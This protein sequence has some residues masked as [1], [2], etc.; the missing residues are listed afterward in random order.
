MSGLHTTKRFLALISTLALTSGLVLVTPPAHAALAAPARLAPT[1]PVSNSMPTLS[2]GRVAGATSYTVQVDD[3]PAFDTPE[4]SVTTVNSRWVPT[5]PLKDGSVHWRV[6]AIN[7]AGAGTWTSADIQV[8]ATAA[9]TPISPIDSVSL[10]QPN[11]PPLLTWSP[12]AGATGYT[13]QVANDPDFVTA[14][15]SYAVPGTSLVLPNPQ[16][17]RQEGYFW[18]VQAKRDSGGA[19]TTA[20]SDPAHYLVGALPDVQPH[21]DMSS[22][23]P[24]QDVVLKWLPVPGATKYEIKVG[25]DPDI[26]N[27][28]VQPPLLV[29]GTSYSPPTTYK[30]DQ[31]YWQVRA[32]NTQGDRSEWPAVPWVFQRNWPERPE[33]IHPANTINPAVGDDFYYQWS[34]VNTGDGSV[35]RH[36]SEYQLDV[37]RDPNF[38]P[39]SFE[40]CAVAATTFTAGYVGEKCMPAQGIVTYW[41]VRAID[42]PA[43]VEGIYSEIHSFIYNSGQVQQLSPANGATVDVPTLVWSPARD[44][45]RYYVEIRNAADV[46]VLSAMTYGTSWTA[47]KVLDPAA[48]PFTWTVQAEDGNES[49]SPKYPGRSFSLSGVQPDSGAP[50]LTPLTGGSGSSTRFPSL[51]W[52][53]MAN[54]KSYRIDIG[55]HGSGFVD[56]D[57]TSHINKTAYPYSA[58]TDTDAHYLNQGSYDW[59]VHAYDAAGLLIGTGPVGTF[60][61]DNLAPVAG[62]KIALTGRALDGAPGASCAAALG[63]VVSEEDICLGVPATPVLD[64]DSVPGAAGYLVYLANDRALTN[65][66]FSGAATVNSRWTPTSKMAKSALADNTALDAYYWYI[67]PCKLIDPLVCNPDPISTNQVATHAFR[68]VAPAVELLPEVV[69]PPTSTGINDVTFTWRDY[70]DTNLETTFPDTADGVPAEVEATTYRIDVSQSSTFTSHVLGFPATVDQT[71]YTPFNRTLPEGTL[72]WRVQAIDVEGNALAWSTTRSFSKSSPRVSLV[73]PVNG[74]TASGATPFRWHSAPGASSYQLEVYTLASPPFQVGHRIFGVT[75]I[76]QTAYQY[77]KYLP[78]ITTDYIWRVRYLD[79]AGKPGPWSREAN[80][81]PSTPD[82]RFSVRPAAMALGAPANGAYQPAAAPYFTWYPVASAATYYLE[83]RLQ[84]ST[85]ISIKALTAAQAF[86]ATSALRDGVYEWRVTA[87]DPNGGTLAQSGWR[88]FVVDGTRPVVVSKSPVTTA[89]RTANFIAKFSEPVTGVSGT[90]MRLFV[91]GRTSPLAAAVTVSADRK[92]AILNPGANLVA[93]KLYTLKLTSGIKDRAGNTLA[94][95]SWSARAK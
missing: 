43:N 33:L 29:F 57:D 51:S 67:R 78:A 35:L 68:K 32:V 22:G 74:A 76:K 55:V 92:T 66:V 5:S 20:W 40:S 30:N 13:V 39:G 93:G 31:F 48:G 14:M 94:A 8:S 41:R 65:R 70:L 23:E 53:P 46:K 83:A 24:M 12:T 80:D 2:W 38:S 90:T 6:R 7:S 72:Y 91:Q 11:D 84:G 17:F 25:L 3:S 88:T 95:T 49:L 28:L 60:T 86:A 63:Q 26:D 1:G 69:A 61:I 56:P 19:L 27:N 18:R 4:F 47:E 21:P 85:G 59:W 15:T 16:P 77:T 37:S 82:G 64:W 58:A 10:A 87:R 50:P 34:P 89:A 73:S 36:A 42:R 62:Q 79:A 71:T 81:P 44:A 45:Q 54:A 75:G 9:P 52:E